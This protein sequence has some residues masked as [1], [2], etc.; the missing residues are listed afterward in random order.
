M[1]RTFLIASV[2][3]ATAGAVL[4]SGTAGRVDPGFGTQGVVVIAGAGANSDSVVFDVEAQSDGRILAAGYAASG[5]FLDGRETIE[6]RIQRLLED[7]RIDPAFGTQGAV[8]LYGDPGRGG[9][10]VRALH[11]DAQGGI[12]A[13]GRAI[14]AT[15]TSGRGKK[16]QTI[17]DGGAVVVR[18]HPDGALDTSF[19]ELGEA[20]LFGLMDGVQGLVPLGDGRVLVL[21]RGPVPAD[22]SEGRGRKGQGGANAESTGIVIARLDATGRLDPTYGLDG[23]ARLDLD[24]QGN[25][26]YP[27]LH[28]GALQSDGRLVV[29][30]T[31]HED[32][33]IPR[34]GLVRFEPNGARDIGFGTLVS[35][36]YLRSLLVDPLDRIVVAGYESG[37]VIVRRYTP[38]AGTGDA[39]FG[40]AGEVR[41]GTSANAYQ[42][43]PISGHALTWD[44][45][46]L[47][48]A[49]NEWV[50]ADS[51]VDGIHT[52]ALRMLEDGTLD[53]TFAGGPDGFGE[54]LLAMPSFDAA[55]MPNGDFIFGGQSYAS[56]SLADWAIGR[57]LGN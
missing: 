49:C 26:D 18:L 1:Q 35:D 11:I 53:P 37:D 23:I 24:P 52:F 15:G 31:L 17:Y 7:G 42:T 8:R 50:D 56:D 16:Q 9:E 21:G 39:S 32:Y 54:R 38:D 28:G 10:G 20:R 2:L 33:S 48:L 41:I 22:G 34:V 3:V 19:G 36:I 14:V 57:V 45:A 29:M 51:S 5:R 55:R 47:V 25:G 44:G 4:A 40:V 30:T 6:W 43:E 12:W 46:R 13:A 27:T